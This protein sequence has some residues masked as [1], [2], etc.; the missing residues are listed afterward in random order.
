MSIIDNTYYYDN[1]IRLSST[2]FGCRYSDLFS[3][4]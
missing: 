4:K 1:K 2:L 3:N